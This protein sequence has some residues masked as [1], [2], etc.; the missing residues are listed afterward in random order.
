MMIG[1]T[2]S[3]DAAARAMLNLTRRD[4]ARFEA[5]QA[6]L[7][8]PLD[9]DSVTWRSSVNERLLELLGGSRAAFYL[10]EPDCEPIVTTNVDPDVSIEYLTQWAM[11]DPVLP[12]RAR[13][14][15]EA[16]LLSWL[17]PP[18]VRGGAFYHEFLLRH[19]VHRGVAFA[20][21][22]DNGATAWLSVY[23]DDS[24]DNSF[25]TLGLA[26]VRLLAPAFRAGTRQRAGFATAVADLGTTIDGLRAAAAIAD[27]NGRLLHRNP[28]MASV[29]G[30]PGDETVLMSAIEAL[31][32]PHSEGLPGV[33]PR[34]GVAAL[35]IA[36]GGECHELRS[37]PLPDGL[38]LVSL[39]PLTA[40]PVQVLLQQ[41]GLTSREA[42]V[43]S[44]L[45]RGSTAKRVAVDLGI[46]LHTVRRHT[47]RILE[48]L[49][50]RSKTQLAAVVHD[51]LAG[52][53]GSILSQR[54]RAVRS[55]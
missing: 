49:G 37:A 54:T 25:E 11:D 46:S 24:A 18:E 35:E 32:D 15:L 3:D 12:I 9:H 51:L 47:E 7:L 34:R 48:K 20:T 16:F 36:L 14:G 4:L 41:S 23:P 29:C 33:I 22:L 21:T 28:L 40:P 1:R 50:L 27:A 55:A 44:C 43:A 53:P 8:S 38:F 45:M 13:C 26:I 2:G 39:E 42:E 10:P 52:T 31:M 5:L 19:A 30:G 6:E 17:H